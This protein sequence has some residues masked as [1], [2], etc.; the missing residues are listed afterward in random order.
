MVDKAQGFYEGGSSTMLNL[1]PSLQVTTMVVVHLSRG[2][3]P[4]LS[5][6]KGT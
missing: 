2:S 1:L 6:G 3:Y 5:G 4:A